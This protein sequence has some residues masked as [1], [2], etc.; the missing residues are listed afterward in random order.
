[1]FV[2]FLIFLVVIGGSIACVQG[3]MSASRLELFP[4]LVYVLLWAAAALTFGTAAYFHTGPIAMDFFIAGF[5]VIA[6]LGVFAMY[7]RDRLIL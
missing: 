3:Y 7:Y 2:P 6:L 4:R 5:V 1:V